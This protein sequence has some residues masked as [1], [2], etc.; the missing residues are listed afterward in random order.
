VTK[1]QD[2]EIKTGLIGSEYTVVERDGADAR[3][4]MGEGTT[5]N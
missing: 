2:T 5:S 1:K 4:M 3:K